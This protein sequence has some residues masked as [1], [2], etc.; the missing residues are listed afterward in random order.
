MKEECSREIE[1]DVRRYVYTNA[2]IC[3]IYSTVGRSI[4]NIYDPR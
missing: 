2:G 4:A 1:Q 3:Y